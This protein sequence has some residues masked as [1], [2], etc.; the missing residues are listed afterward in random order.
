MIRT[1]LGYYTPLVVP[2]RLTGGIT[3]YTV[4]VNVPC[5]MLPDKKLT[6]P[7]IYCRVLVDTDKPSQRKA[8]M[9]N[10]PKKSKKKPKKRSLGPLTWDEKENVGPG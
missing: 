5:E 6:K 9:T 10:Y 8:R 3:A 7:Y 2:D 1:Q 4:S